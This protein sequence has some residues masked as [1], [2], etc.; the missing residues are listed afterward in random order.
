[1]HLLKKGLWLAGLTGL[2]AGTPLAHASLHEVTTY[3]DAGHEAPLDER[4]VELLNRRGGAPRSFVL[5][6]GWDAGAPLNLE[7]LHD[8]QALEPSAGLTLLTDQELDEAWVPELASLARMH[9]LTWVRWAYDLPSEEEIR[10]LNA[11]GPARAIWIL[12]AYLGPE[13]NHGLEKLQVPFEITYATSSYPRFMDRDGFLALPAQIPLSFAADYWPGYTHMD[14][15]NLIPQ[16]IWLRVTGSLPYGEQWDHLH[17]VKRLLGVTVESEGAVTDGAWDRF[18]ALPV[19]WQR[20]GFP[21][22]RGARELEDFTASGPSA[23]ARLL[24]V[25]LGELDSDLAQSLLPELDREDASLRVIVPFP[26]TRPFAP[27]D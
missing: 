27:H 19:E 22:E 23:E 25:D 15:F 21:P 26:R 16:P 4:A 9:P 5:S 11:A 20:V 10:R 17:G 18:G 7:I 8:L 24:V 2:W 6:F 12:K 1:M 13:S 3:Y 14:L